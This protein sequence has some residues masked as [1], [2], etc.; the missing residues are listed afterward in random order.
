MAFFSIT[1]RNFE[2]KNVLNGKTYLSESLNVLY[3]IISK[4]TQHFFKNIVEKI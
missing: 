2:L 4:T 1:H 3:F